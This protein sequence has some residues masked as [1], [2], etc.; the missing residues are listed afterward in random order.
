M[1]GVLFYGKL[2]IEQG[3]ADGFIGFQNRIQI[4]YK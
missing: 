3:C 4:F 2:Q 1:E